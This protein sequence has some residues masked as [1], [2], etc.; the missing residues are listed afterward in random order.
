MLYIYTSNNNLTFRQG[1]RTYTYKEGDL[2]RSEHIGYMLQ[3]WSGSLI[4]VDQ[5]EGGSVP[6][7]SETDSGEMLTSTSNLV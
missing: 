2:I 3:N 1:N 7:V 5:L 4:K 6:G